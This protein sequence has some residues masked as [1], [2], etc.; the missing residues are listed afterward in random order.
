MNAVNGVLARRGLDPS[1]FGNFMT[2]FDPSSP[3][4]QP[5]MQP[6][7]PAATPDK[8]PMTMMADPRQSFTQSVNPQTAP[9]PQEPSQ[10]MQQEQLSPQ[11]AEANMILG[12]FADRLQH[13]S[14]MKDKAVSA[15][16]NQINANNQL[17]QPATQPSV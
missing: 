2:Q 11:D 9:A 13:H 16:V 5:G 4:A 6:P 8:S 3:S 10:P 1:Q 17:Q 12:A 7:T 14:K 15:I